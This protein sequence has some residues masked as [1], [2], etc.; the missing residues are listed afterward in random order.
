MINSKKSK[1]AVIAVL[2]TAL[3]LSRGKNYSSG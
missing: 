1:A 2:M 3:N